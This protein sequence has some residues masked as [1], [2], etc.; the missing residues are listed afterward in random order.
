MTSRN[1]RVLFMEI[2]FGLRKS[3]ISKMQTTGQNGASRPE[4]SRSC[5]GL[6]SFKLNYVSPENHNIEKLD[7]KN[8]K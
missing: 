2:H 6:A 5:F 7:D 8:E 3:K 1:A 4:N